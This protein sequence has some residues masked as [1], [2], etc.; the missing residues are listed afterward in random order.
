MSAGRFIALFLALCVLAP[1]MAKAATSYTIHDGDQLQVMV[2]GGQGLAAV[3]VPVQPQPGT[4]ASLSQI[5]T[6]LSDGTITYP[7]IGSIGVAGLTPDDAAKRIAA[8]L[9]AYVR[10][11]QVSVIVQKQLLPSIKV[12]GAVDHG[13][14]LELQDGD[15]LLDALAKAGVSPYS[16]ADL[17]HITLN[18]IVDGVAHV[19]TLDL[20]KLLLNADYSEDPVLQPGDVVYVPKARQVNLANWTNLPFALYYLYLLVTPGVN[21]SGYIP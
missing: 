20:Y 18:R 5:V 21:H 1:A 10:S 16:Y 15:R 8:A 12:L 19:Y 3:Q 17:N 11:P 14:Q 13:G 2:F 9:A 6:V 4:I 7:L